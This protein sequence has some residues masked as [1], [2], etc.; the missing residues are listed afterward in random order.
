MTALSGVPDEALRALGV[1]LRERGY[2]F[3]TPTPATHARVNAR[4]GSDQARSLQD[5]LGWSRPF[6]RGVIADEI[7]LLLHSAG[8][9]EEADGLWRSRLR[10]STI[11]NEL[12]FHS[13]F[14]TTGADAVFF[15][16]DTYRFC[17]AI[18]HHLRTLKAPVKRVADIGCGSGAGGIIIARA[19]P[20][21]RVMMGD[22]NEA[23][24]RLAR[25]N[26]EI[27][28]LQNLEVVKSDLMKNIQGE[29]DMVVA[30]PPYLR[31]PLQRTYRHG[32]GELGERLSLD[33]IEA[34]IDRLAPG[35]TLLLYTG[36]AIRDGEDLFGAA[37]AAK[38]E[39]AGIAYEYRELDPDVFGEELEH[40]PYDRVDRIAVVQLTA[41]KLEHA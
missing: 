36:S 40:A 14:P 34:A 6:A 24:L 29:F 17:T 38:L 4:D 23:A 1:L 20:E 26:V 7:F 32:G 37:A 15:G 39:E 22:I 10:A 19:L 31:D 21:A 8:A 41:R 27:S 5:A 11:G 3:I 2:R 16:P 28:G 12:F 35:G 9:L 18:E 30:N 33:I 13:A 25:I